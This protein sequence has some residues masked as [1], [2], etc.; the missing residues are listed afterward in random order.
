MLYNNKY[1]LIYF[2]L[3]FYFSFLSDSF[4]FCFCIVIGFSPTAL[5]LTVSAAVTF[6]MCTYVCR[7]VCMCTFCCVLQLTLLFLSFFFL[8]AVQSF[9]PHLLAHTQSPPA[10]SYLSIY[11]SLSKKGKKNRDKRVIWKKKLS[12]INAL[13]QQT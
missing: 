6:P 4:K 7:Y 8:L 3:L 9:F 10:V 12:I 5:A 2:L 11:S 1:K 13:Q